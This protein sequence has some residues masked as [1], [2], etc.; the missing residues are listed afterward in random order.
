MMHQKRRLYKIAN[1]PDFWH[2]WSRLGNGGRPDLVRND[3]QI[4]AC[5]IADLQEDVEAGDKAA[6]VLFR[7]D[8]GNNQGQ[9]GLCSS[10]EPCAISNRPLG[11]ARANSGV[12]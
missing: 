2:L 4:G 7:R 10:W 8:A 5:P 6:K 1:V 11:V 12:R 3:P 9:P